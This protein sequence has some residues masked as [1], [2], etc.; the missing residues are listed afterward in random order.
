MHGG[1]LR[2]ERQ[3][4]RGLGPAQCAAHR[5]TYW[6]VV[7]V[8]GTR[9]ARSLCSLSA[10]C[11]A[12]GR[13]GLLRDPP[14]LKGCHFATSVARAGFT[15][16]RDTRRHGQND[17]NH[18]AGTARKTIA[19]CTRTPVRLSATARPCTLIRS[20]PTPKSSRPHLHRACHA[21]RAQVQPEGIARDPGAELS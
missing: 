7:V 18:P 20:S 12:S 6:H 5:H 19:P 13:P 17:H 3:V 2:K 16:T 4:I 9:P 14:S 8:C 15:T 21:T 1:A 10:L 11:S